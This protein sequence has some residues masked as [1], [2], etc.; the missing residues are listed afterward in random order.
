VSTKS[1]VAFYRAY[2][3][4]TNVLVDHVEVSTVEVD[5][6]LERLQKADKHGIILMSANRRLWIRRHGFPTTICLWNTLPV[7]VCQL[8]PDSFKARLNT[9]QLMW[10]APA[11]FLIHLAPLHRF[12][13]LLLFSAP[14]WTAV[15]RHAP[16]PSSRC[17]I[18][19]SPSWHP[20]GRRRR[21]RRR[22]YSRVWLT[23]ET[24][25]TQFDGNNSHLTLP[26][27]LYYDD[28]NDY[29]L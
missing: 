3:E 20:V 19:R 22:L 27:S 10:M 12:Y 21:R 23:T 25:L 29:E 26:L 13:L 24:L 28:N 14:F 15:P 11:L 5:D 16:L 2:N 4:S 6:L 17:D 18:T 7:D 8:P 9:I 1:I